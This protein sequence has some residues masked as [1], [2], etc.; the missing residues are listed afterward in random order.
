MDLTGEERPSDS[1]YVET[2]WRTHSEEGGPFI[3]VANPGW[4]I[5]VTRLQGE[6][7]VTVRGPET[8]PTPAFAPPDAAFMGIQFRP[9]T[10]MPGLP[11][12]RMIDRRDV[13]LPGASSRTFWLGGASWEFPGFENADTFVDRL[14]REGLLVFDPLV[15]DV[16]RG[17]P[18]DTSLRTAQR[19]FLRATGLTLNTRTQI[20]RARHATSL[21]KGGRSIVDT[22]FEA[23]Y[24]DQPHLT[25][26]LKRFI[27]LT[28]AQ[29]LDQGRSERLS[30]ILETAPLFHSADLLLD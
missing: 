1:P 8:G 11:P 18:L 19:R 20:E 17:A 23:G 26:S 7:F 22:V 14:V 4:E 13:N 28:P 24:F 30:L 9:G 2:V 12:G 25:R 29:V 15:E 3:S 10:L 16:L 21:L 6:T 27:G 5:V